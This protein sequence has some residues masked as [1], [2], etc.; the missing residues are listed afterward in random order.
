MSLNV[1]EH[2][3]RHLMWE[4]RRTMTEREFGRLTIGELVHYRERKLEHLLRRV[5]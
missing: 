4:I 2:T 5:S 3:A 1:S